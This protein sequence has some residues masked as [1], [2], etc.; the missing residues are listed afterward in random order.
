M[1]RLVSDMTID[2]LKELINAAIDK[3]LDEKENE[4]EEVKESVIKELIK[5]Q[6]NYK[7]GNQGRDFLEVCKELGID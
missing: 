3:K 4:H 6:E 1:N 2:E 5:Q 7:K